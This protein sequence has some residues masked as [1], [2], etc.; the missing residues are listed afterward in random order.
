[1]ERLVVKPRHMLEGNINIGLKTCEDVDSFQLAC[2][3]VR[4]RALMMR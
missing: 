3:K 4:W 1:M 2:D